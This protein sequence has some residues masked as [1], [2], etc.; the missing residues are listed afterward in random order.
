MGTTNN[1]SIVESFVSA[2]SNEIGSQNALAIAISNFCGLKF[3]TARNQVCGLCWMDSVPAGALY[4]YVVA[5]LPLGMGRERIKFGNSEITVRKN[6]GELAKALRFLEDDGYCL[7]LVEPPGF[8][9]AEGLRF[10]ELL[11]AE[12]YYL[13]GIINTPDGLFE[14]T[15][16]RPVLIVIG[17]SKRQSI[18]VAELEGEEQATTLAHAL[19]AEIAGNSLSEGMFI[20]PRK[21]IGFTSLKAEQQLSWLGT[22]YKE[23]DSVQLG[24]IAIAINT[25][26]SG[27]RHVAQENAIYIPMLGSSSVTHDISQVTIKHHNMLQVILMDK[28]HNEYLS[29][30]FQ[31]ELGKMVLNSLVCGACIPKI[32]KSALAVARVAL[33]AIEEQREIAFTHKRLSDL[34][35]AISDFQS[36]LALNPKSAAEIKLQLESMLEQIGGLSDADKIMSLVRSGES[37]IIEYKEAFSL[38]IRKGSKEKYIEL[39]ALKT[40][41]AFLNTNGGTLLV[42]ISDG[43]EIKG[44]REEVYK[45]HKS[46][47]AFLLHFKNQIKQRIGEQYYPFINHKLVNVLGVDVLMV[48]CGEA[49]SP[50]FLDGNEFY[51]RTNPATD[52]LDG[53]KLVEYVRNHFK[54]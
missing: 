22:H 48:E 33:P 32:N 8:G 23:Y 46:S 37:K 28:A 52:K 5:D 31:S 49:S 21:F 1:S 20:A 4:D 29:A 14:S 47:D 13:C 30:F 17:R 24:D 42:G 38:D 9:M 40:I 53:P 39:S 11:N 44:I 45:F 19:V 26:K 6:W 36:E 12:G 35:C 15:S 27:E 51:V 3:Q 2:L 10:E 7:T 43:G 54:M 41:V 18:F 16:I 34:K 25:V 50:C